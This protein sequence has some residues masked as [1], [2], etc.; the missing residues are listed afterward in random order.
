MR[1]L[2]KLA[3]AAAMAAICCTMIVP[4]TASAEEVEPCAATCPPH[5]FVASSPYTETVT[6]T[7]QY[8]FGYIE[9]EDGTK[10]PMYSTCGVVA[11]YTYVDLTCK[12]C[13]SSY[14]NYVTNT[15]IT[16]SS[17]GQ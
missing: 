15:Q 16:H 1:F 4:V 14:P 10:E 11:V 2:K 6:S 8:I 9:H 5:T 7:H 3:V 17:C 12:F 13:G